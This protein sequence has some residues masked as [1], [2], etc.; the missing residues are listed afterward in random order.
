[1][2]VGCWFVVVLCS[3]FNVCCLLFRCCL[4]FVV[5]FSLFVACGWLLVLR[6]LSAVVSC[7]LSVVVG[8]CALFVFV[9]SC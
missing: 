8:S 2:V 5:R 6:W 3:L 1:M 7:V 9:V 4:V